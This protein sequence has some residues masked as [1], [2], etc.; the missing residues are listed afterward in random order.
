MFVFSINFTNPILELYRI[1]NQTCEKEE[2]E[3]FEAIFWRI[4][5]LQY[6]ILRNVQLMSILI[7]IYMFL[8]SLCLYVFMSLCYL[9]S[10]IYMCLGISVSS[11]K[12]T[13]NSSCF[14]LVSALHAF[15]SPIFN[16]TR[17]K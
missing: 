14:H 4:G 11:V 12:E 5:Q 8:W 2:F 1:H 16:Y 17:E 7:H 9:C 6:R 15:I 3:D 13:P 10:K